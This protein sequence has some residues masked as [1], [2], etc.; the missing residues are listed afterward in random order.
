LPPPDHAKEYLMMSLRLREG[1]SLSRYSSFSGD[2]V[3]AKKLAD[4]QEIGMITLDDDRIRATEA[5]RMVL[6][7]LIAEL[8][9]G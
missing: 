5:G 8:S 9:A 6:N 7:T 2:G 4:M 1:T 3:S